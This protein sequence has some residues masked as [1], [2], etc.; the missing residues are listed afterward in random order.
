M[1]TVVNG[2]IWSGACVAGKEI[3]GL[4]KNGVVFYKREICRFW[5]K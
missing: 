1:G 4:V 5:H 2:N 3:T